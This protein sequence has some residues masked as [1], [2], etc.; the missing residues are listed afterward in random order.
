MTP[1]ASITAFGLLTMAAF[2]ACILMVM[3]KLCRH[4]FPLQGVRTKAR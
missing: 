1:S 4:R 2:V 3:S